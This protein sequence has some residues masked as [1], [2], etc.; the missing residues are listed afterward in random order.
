MFTPKFPLGPLPRKRPPRFLLPGTCI[1]IP[2]RHL[3]VRP[4]TVQIYIRT[5]NLSKEVQI[6]E[7]LTEVPEEIR[8]AGGTH[9]AP[10]GTKHQQHHSK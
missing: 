3:V 10:V 8:E 2:L 1:S 5:I 4:E 9:W 6:S 7:E